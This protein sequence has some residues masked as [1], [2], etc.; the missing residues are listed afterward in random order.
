MS[1]DS[2]TARVCAVEPAEYEAWGRAVV[3]RAAELLLA[4][5]PAEQRAEPGK[6]ARRVLGGRGYISRHVVFLRPDQPAQLAVWLFAVPAGHPYDFAPPHDRVGAGLLQD[7]T[8]EL[9]SSRF[10]AG[11]ARSGAFTWKVHLDSRYEGY[12]FAIKVD[13]TTEAPEDVASDLASQV[14]HSLRR[15]ELLATL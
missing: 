14:L 11:M 10:A 8:N 12:R 5:I 4:E 7:A 13:A 6:S 15:A 2:A 9:S 1:A 3:D